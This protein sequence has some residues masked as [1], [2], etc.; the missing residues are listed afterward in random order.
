MDVILSREAMAWL[1]SSKAS[2]TKSCA[3]SV[4]CVRRG[5]ELLRDIRPGRVRGVALEEL[6]D[7]GV[8]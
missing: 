1:Y 2:S 7:K 3:C 8:V 6:G 4:L 5:A